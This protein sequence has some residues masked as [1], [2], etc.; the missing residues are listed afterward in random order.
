MLL[1]LLLS[2]SLSVCAVVVV[3]CASLSVCVL[4]CVCMCVSLLR[5]LHQRGK[6][7]LHAWGV[8]LPCSNGTLYILSLIDERDE[9]W[10]CVCD[11]VQCDGCCCCVWQCYADSLHGVSSLCVSLYLLCTVYHTTGLLSTP[12]PVLLCTFFRTPHRYL[13]VF[14]G[15][16]SACVQPAVAR[17]FFVSLYS[18]A[19]MAR[20]APQRASERL[21]VVLL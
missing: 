14:V 18:H 8:L 5:V 16:F 15:R 6:R 3:C 13:C 19:N 11:A 9:A 12:T 7:T 1:L 21:F 20:C 4:L 10:K 2:L 17:R